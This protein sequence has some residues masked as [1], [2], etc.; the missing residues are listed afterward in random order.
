MQSSPENPPPRL[1]QRLDRSVGELN[2]LL[3][4]L[5]IGLACLDLVLFATITLSGEIQRRRDRG[6]VA[7]DVASARSNVA[8]SSRRTP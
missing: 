1:L 4:I 6:F 5:A 7:F 8:D 3:A 2:A